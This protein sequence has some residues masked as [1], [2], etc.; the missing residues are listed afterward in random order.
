M[1]HKIPILIQLKIQGVR[2]KYGDSLTTL[3]E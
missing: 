2:K 1:S 3:N